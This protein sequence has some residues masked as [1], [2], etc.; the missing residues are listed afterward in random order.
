MSS[1]YDLVVHFPLSEN[2]L[3]VTMISAP[4]FKMGLAD[5][6][7][8]SVPTVDDCHQNSQTCS[9]QS[10]QACTACPRMSGSARLAPQDAQIHV[11]Y[12]PD[13]TTPTAS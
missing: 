7:G 4:L 9:K 10:A 6:P 13:N 12:V 2:F 1:L 3:K 8:A 5:R 11:G